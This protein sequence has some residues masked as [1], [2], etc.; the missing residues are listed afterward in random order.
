MFKRNYNLTE[1]SFK[2]IFTDGVIKTV[3]C[4]AVHNEFNFHFIIFINTTDF[5]HNEYFKINFS[6]GS[7]HNITLQSVIYQIV[8]D[9][10]SNLI[11]FSQC[12]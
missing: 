8:N 1:V 11:K 4:H 6:T 5:C 12:N 7:V 10:K 9:F 3:H 2:R